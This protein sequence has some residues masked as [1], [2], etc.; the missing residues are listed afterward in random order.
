M[1]AYTEFLKRKQER[2]I[3]SGFEKPRDSMNRMLFEWQKDID[4]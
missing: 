3:S 4:H 2:A 1:E